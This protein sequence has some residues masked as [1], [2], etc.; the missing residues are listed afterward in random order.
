[1]LYITVITVS[2][3]T[4]PKTQ[5]LS[6]GHGAWVPLLC[7]GLIFGIMAV[8][9]VKLNQM[10]EGDTLFEYSAKIAGKFVAY[11]LA[12]FY[13]LFFMLDSTFFC[14]T[15]FDLVKVHFLPKSPEWALILVSMPFLGFIAY[16]GLTNAGRL[17]ELIG[18]VFLIVSLIISVTMFFEGRLDNILPLYIPS[19]TG[20]YFNAIKDTIDQFVGLSLL[21]LIPISKADKKFSRVVF[22]TFIGIALFYIID[23]Y[24]CYAIIGMDE[25]K[26]YNYPLIDAIRLVEYKRVEFFQRVDIA[27]QTIGFMRVFVAKGIVY[28]AVVEYVCKILPKARRITVVVCLGVLMYSIDVFASYVPEII[29][30]LFF[31]RTISVILAS[32]IIPLTLLIIAKVKQHGKKNT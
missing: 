19:E 28:L 13:I 8:I 5:A 2:V 7:T 31:M 9:T 25:I 23:V 1:M 17:S 15:F 21:T 18:F 24:G 26:Q 20:Q 32:F 12:F 22:L 14:I 10:F 29:A 27:Y 3:I 16:K 6:A 30:K 11:I 4:A